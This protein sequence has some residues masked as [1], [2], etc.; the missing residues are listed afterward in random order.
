ML[1]HLQLYVLLLTL[2]RLTV[3]LL[4]HLHKVV[5]VELTIPKH[6]VDEGLRYVYRSFALLL[7][8]HY[9]LSDFT[10]VRRWVV[11]SRL[12]KRPLVRPIDYVFHLGLD[13]FGLQRLIR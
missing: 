8:R 1:R 5:E 6:A 4:K 11:F 7:E 10:D 2:L 9:V 13:E 3:F 12:D